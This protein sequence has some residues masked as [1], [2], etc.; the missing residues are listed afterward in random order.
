M[1]VLGSS[2]PIASFYC[3]RKNKCS[4]TEEFGD[5]SSTPFPDI[6]A[7]LQIKDVLLELMRRI[8]SALRQQIY[9]IFVLYTY[10]FLALAVL[11][12]LI[13]WSYTNSSTSISTESTTTATTSA[14]IATGHK[15]A[16]ANATNAD[17]ATADA[18]NP[19]GMDSDF[20]LILLMIIMCMMSLA[21]HCG[22]RVKA[23]RKRA[24]IIK[25]FDGKCKY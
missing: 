22:W 13:V 18:D 23:T 5:F 19:F 15:N 14:P 1:A 17:N 7:D 2:I 11:L 24:A 4:L 6:V 10:A 8:N 3:R 21:C 12:S 16:T 9:G 25:E 20:W